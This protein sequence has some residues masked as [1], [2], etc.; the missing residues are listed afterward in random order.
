[1][2]HGFVV[3][4]V[5]LLLEDRRLVA[6][7]GYE[8]E[9]VT[10]VECLM[11]DSRYR[12]GKNNLLNGCARKCHCA[13]SYSVVSNNSIVIT[14]PA[15]KLKAVGSN[16]VNRAV[17]Y[18]DILANVEGEYL[19]LIYLIKECLALGRGEGS[20]NAVCEGI[21]TDVVDILTEDNIEFAD[22]FL[23]E[24]VCTDVLC[25][26][27]VCAEKCGICEC[28]VTDILRVFFTL[29]VDEAFTVGECAFADMSSVCGKDNRGKLLVVAECIVTDEACTR[30]VKLG[31]SILCE[32]R[33]T[34]GLYVVKVN[35]GE[36]VAVL[37]RTL[38]N[39]GKVFAESN[40]LKA[41]TKCECGL[42]DLGK[43]GK[44]DRCKCGSV[45]TVGV[46]A[47]FVDVNR[48]VVL[49][50]VLVVNITGE[51]A[52]ANRDYTAEVD[53]RE[54]CTVVEGKVTNDSAITEANGLKVCRAVECAIKKSNVVT[55]G[56]RGKGT[57][58]YN[59]IDSKFLVLLATGILVV[60]LTYYTV[61][62]RVVHVVVEC[63]FTNCYVVTDNDGG[64]LGTVS[65]CTGGNGEVVT[66]SDLCYLTARECILAD[67]NVASE[68]EAVKA[69]V[70]KCICT[71]L[72]KIAKL[73]GVKSLTL[74]E[75]VV[76]N[77]GYRGNAD[78]TESGTVRE[79]A[80]T[81]RCDLGITYGKG[82]EAGSGENDS[83][84]ACVGKILT[85]VHSLKIAVAIC[86]LEGLNSCVSECVF[87]NNRYVLT[88][89]YALKRITL[90]ECSGRNN[91]S[92]DGDGLKRG[93]VGECVLADLDL[94]R[95]DLNA[96]KSGVSTEC[97]RTYRLKCCG[98]LNRFD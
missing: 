93:T 18:L 85:A 33:R 32:C 75:C 1:M 21:V 56:K 12:S 16:S 88:K 3:V 7:E 57:V 38:C 34:D 54:L 19:L 53:I 96:L 90:V 58:H 46:L 44:V 37:E 74:G 15:D 29:K 69:G 64:K 26:C 81:D 13:D 70:L 50:G 10:A 71:D 9:L 97:I 39:L 27:K 11:T 31:K 35:L 23:I 66:D 80:V 73:Y 65:K 91:R 62:F 87:A 79:C 36:I 2:L 59:V 25:A 22:L 43:R 83:V 30:E 14:H 94:L 68:L 4:A 49:G 84:T 92:I 40:V 17:N 45:V 95:S 63:V 47:L 51:R 48:C 61:G 6:G 77:L 78:R 67:G 5:I 52:L 42:S 8:L 72:G 60:Y 98:K 89:S 20:D 82:V 41:L 24:S 86:K 28:I 55:D 76:A